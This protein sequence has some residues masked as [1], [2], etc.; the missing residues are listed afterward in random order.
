WPKGTRRESCPSRSGRRSG[1]RDRRRSRPSPRAERGSPRR[2]C[3]RTS[4][5]RRGGNR[6]STRFYASA[7]AHLPQQQAAQGG[8]RVLELGE[9]REV[10]Q[11]GHVERLA[12]QPL[13]PPHRGKLLALAVILR[14]FEPSD[15]EQE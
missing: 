4:G 10:V 1:C 11:A 12:G 9:D 13:R 6:P 8:A 2:T 3:H 14:A 5:G 7:E 15:G